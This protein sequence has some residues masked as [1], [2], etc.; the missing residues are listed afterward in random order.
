[1][2]QFKVMGGDHANP[3]VL[4]KGLDIR[5]TANETF[6]VVGAAKDFINEKK[7]AARE[8]EEH[9]VYLRSC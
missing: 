9:K 2:N 6:S 4:G 5:S 7:A 1:M 8:F 3:F